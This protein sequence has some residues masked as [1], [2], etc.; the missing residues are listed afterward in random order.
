[1]RPR[2]GQLAFTGLPDVPLPEGR[3]CVSISE[4]WD[5]HQRAALLEYDGEVAWVVSEDTAYPAAVEVLAE[6]L[7]AV[8]KPLFP[9]ETPPRPVLPFTRPDGGRPSSIAVIGTKEQIDHMTTTGTWSTS[10]LCFQVFPNHPR[11]LRFVCTFGGLKLPYR[12]HRKAKRMIKTCIENSPEVAALLPANSPKLTR[13]LDTLEVQHL[14]AG[15]DGDQDDR[16][17]VVMDPPVE[18]EE[19][20]RIWRL[21]IAGLRPKDPLRGELTSIRHPFKCTTCGCLTHPRRV[22]PASA[23]PGWFGFIPR[24]HQTKTL[25]GRNKAPRRLI[26]IRGVKGESISLRGTR[27]RSVVAQKKYKGFIPGF[28]APHLYRSQN[29]AH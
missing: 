10:W 16:W 9:D 7:L 5:P 29:R 13:A 14:A 21:T 25:W 15:V 20:L 3:D 22:C 18:G 2:S 6:A 23:S 26:K 1:M 24:P 17:N 4:D 28:R 11:P 12:E 27:V 8:C 19:K